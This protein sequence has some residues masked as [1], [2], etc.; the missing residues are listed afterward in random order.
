MEPIRCTAG[1][2]IMAHA[3]HG[4]GEVLRA[5]CVRAFMPEELVACLVAGGDH[6][7]VGAT[8]A[9][10]PQGPVGATGA[11]GP[12]GVV[13]ATGAGGC[14]DGATTGLSETF[15]TGTGCAVV[16]GLASTGVCAAGLLSAE[17]GTTPLLID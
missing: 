2:W 4:N 13:G 6:H 8:G 15:S 14:W 9:T 10:G 11:T 12:Q 17:A 1:R 16:T 5:A 3:A 7:V